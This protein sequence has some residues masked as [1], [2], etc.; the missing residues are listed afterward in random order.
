MVKAGEDFAGD[1]AHL[2]PPT[3]GWGGNTGVQDAHNLAWKLGLVL[4]GTAGE[5]L[6]ATY[7]QERR[8]VD[9]FT[10]E[11]AFTR[12]VL[13]T[14]PSMPRD[15]IQPLVNDMEIELGYVYRSPAVIA[16]DDAG[17]VRP[18]LSEIA[19]ARL[20]TDPRESRAMPGTRAPHYWLRRGGQ[21][22]S[23]LDLCGRHFALLA[24]RG[25]TAWCD[26]ACDTARQLGLGL[27]VFLVGAGGLHDPDDGFA[28]AYDI[29]Q[30]GS[31]LIR[32]DG[33]VAWRARDDRAAG[34]AVLSNALRAILCL[35]APPR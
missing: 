9:E 24:A 18:G 6:L 11:Q 8:P 23:T 7:E 30:T 15:R 19:S 16:A 27:D 28:A 14:D 21:Q 3:G 32:P 25:G 35:S 13:R 17:P 29:E 1:A 26:E 33:F 5:G 2:M 34:A 31:V 4:A 20:H 10:V 22:I 12:Y